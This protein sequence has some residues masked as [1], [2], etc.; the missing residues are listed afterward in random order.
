MNLK[1]GVSKK[2][3]ARQIFQKTNISYPLIR[4]S[5]CAYQGVRNVRFSENLTCLVFF[6]HPFRDS[7]FHIITD[8]LEFR[9]FKNM[10]I[11]WF[12]L[13]KDLMLLKEL[14]TL[15]STAKGM[16]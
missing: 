10:Y 12:P 16:N 6:K 9:F 14:D 5:T 4:T 8:D 11:L 1:R 13:V 15:A 2:N 7:P 3:K